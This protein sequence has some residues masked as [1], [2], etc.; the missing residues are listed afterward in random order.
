MYTPSFV[1]CIGD[2]DAL[3]DMNKVDVVGTSEFLRA[4]PNASVCELVDI[5]IANGKSSIQSERACC[6]KFKV[7]LLR[8]ITMNYAVM[9]FVLRP[10]AML[11]VVHFMESCM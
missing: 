5:N 6:C 11:A 4:T 8:S 3:E 9:S 10:A 2:E 7:P 1:T